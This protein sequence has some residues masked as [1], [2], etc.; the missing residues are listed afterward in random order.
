MEGPDLTG[1]D[2]EN[3]TFLKIYQTHQT[4]LAS[5][6]TIFRYGI[7]TSFQGQTRNKCKQATS[8]QMA[9]FLFLAMIVNT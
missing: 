6:S 8:Q 4:V 9:G 2:L 7:P 5:F 1:R 3:I